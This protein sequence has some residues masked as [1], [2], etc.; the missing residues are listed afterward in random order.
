M[1]PLTR[2]Q[3]GMMVMHGGQQCQVV[4]V[5]DCRALIQPVEKRRRVVVPKTGRHAGREQV[6][7]EAQKAFSIWPDSELEIVTAKNANL[8]KAK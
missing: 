3:I 4:M 8:T 5:N 2:L 1:K 6:F 7:E